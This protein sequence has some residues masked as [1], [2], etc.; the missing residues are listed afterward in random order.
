MQVEF[1]SKVFGGLPVVAKATIYEAEPDV[2]ITYDYA[3]DVRLYWKSGKEFSP[4]LYA[5]V[6]PEEWDRLHMEAT[7]A[8][9]DW[10]N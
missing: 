6:T 7:E 1:E 8:S 3:E 10:C 5:R 4:K 2:G 9:L